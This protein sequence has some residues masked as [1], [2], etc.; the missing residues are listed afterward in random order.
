MMVVAMSAVLAR[1]SRNGIFAVRMIWMMSVWVSKDS[2]N[3]PVWNSAALFQAL[4]TI[5]HR[6]IRDVVED[7]ADRADEQHE[8]RDIADVPSPRHRQVF[9]VDVVGRD[10]R[11]R[12]V[13]EQVVGEHLDRRHRQERQDD[14]GAEH[15]EHVAEIGARAHLDVLRDV[16][17]D[18]AALEN[19]IA[20]YGQ[21]LLEQDDVRSI[22]GDVDGA[23]HRY[24]DIRGLQ[25]RSVVDA[26]A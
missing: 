2:T 1:L 16:A 3:Q 9:R 17:E 15:A 25:G 21:A 4:K 12:K 10:G 13:V 26:I 11:L 7:R 24:A 14:A 20:E 23:V 6:E 8:I 22:L 19:A 5:E 18:F